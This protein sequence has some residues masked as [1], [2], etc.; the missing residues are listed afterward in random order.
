MDVQ[1]LTIEN[2]WTELTKTAGCYWERETR[3]LHKGRPI[4]EWTRLCFETKAEML[5]AQREAQ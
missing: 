2:R 4:T 5:M 3:V 1:D